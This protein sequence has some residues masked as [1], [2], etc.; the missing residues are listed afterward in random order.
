[1][2]AN[3]ATPAIAAANSWTLPQ[4]ISF[5]DPGAS[6]PVSSLLDHAAARTDTPQQEAV[7][8]VTLATG[9]LRGSAA[10]GRHCWN[11]VPMAAAAQQRGIPALGRSACFSSLAAHAAAPASGLAACSIGTA[12]SG[13]AAAGAVGIAEVGAASMADAVTVTAAQPFEPLAVLLGGPLVAGTQLWE[14][15]HSATVRCMPA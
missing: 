14:L 2:T 12:S 13:S 15:A 3:G 10:A 1:M 9:S 8:G 7:H 4:D 11:A 6:P 5:D